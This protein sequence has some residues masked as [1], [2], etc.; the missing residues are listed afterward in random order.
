ME[1]RVAKRCGSRGIPCK[2]RDNSMSFPVSPSTLSPGRCPSKMIEKAKKTVLFHCKR[3]ND[4]GDAVAT[5]AVV[6]SLLTMDGWCI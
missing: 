3:A 4:H 5:T 2:E 6:A 1:R